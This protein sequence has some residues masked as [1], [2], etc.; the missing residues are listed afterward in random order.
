[1][2]KISTK[3]IQSQLILYF[4]IAILVPVIVISIIASKFIYNEI[5]NRAESKSISD[6]N[7]AGEIYNHR[8][9]QIESITRLTAGRSFIISSLIENKAD[10]LYKE[11]HTILQNEKLDIFTIVDKN[12]KVICRG[13]NSFN[14]GDYITSDKFIKRVLETKSTVSGTD[15]VSP[16]E[17]KK[18][19]FELADRAYMEVKPTLMSRERSEKFEKNGMMMKSASPLF[20]KNK[21]I[22][23]VL[24]S[25][26][27]LNR[28]YDIVDKINNVVHEN[29]VYKGQD[30]G[31]VT[32]FEYDVRI[33]T[34]VKNEDG[35]Y[36]VSTLVSE[37]VYDEVILAGQKWIGDAF[38]VNS[39]YV[40]AYKPIRDINDRVIGILYVGILKQPFNDLLLNTILIFSSIAIVTGIIIFFVA[41]MFA[42]KISAP[43]RKLE[44]WAKQI[45]DGTYKSNIAIKAPREIE[46]LS[47]SLNLMAKQLEQEKF[48][49][50]NW[51]ETLEN[52]VNQRTE[53]LKRINDQLFRSEKL[54]SIGKLAAGVAHEINNP[55]TG[56]LTNSSLMLEDLEE[57]DPR[58]EDL[59][60][61]V[62]ETIRCREI[63]KRLLDF[64]RQTKPQKKMTDLNA[65]IENIILL[66]RNQ[67]A[68]RNII[69]KKVLD[70][71]IPQIM[72][73]A[74][75]IQQVFINFILNAS[76]AMPNGGQLVV[77]T[78]LN[79]ARDY[80]EIKFSD[81]G[82]GISEKD[83]RRI[84]DPFFTTK[85]QGTG[86]G[87]SISHGIIE[88]HGGKI[89]LDS[90][91]GKGTCFT[92][93]MPVNYNSDIDD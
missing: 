14:S 42:K 63:V 80:I 24:M 31:T 73:D 5:T 37:E 32:I 85:Q 29:E 3:S 55:L 16:D 8:I 52:K 34:N 53:E 54:A 15:I 46:S 38:V 22:V 4:T 40:S 90:E 86:L 77:N 93:F 26:V 61:V 33:A 88:R 11:L 13:R 84:F 60:V 48:E 83:K 72:V 49:L 36:A 9:S 41:V 56:V 89:I 51:A 66:V 64:A 10:T 91:L 6:L 76:E 35:S 67:S 44:E 74:D 47:L 59:Q 27:L 57:N 39:W 2:G 82:C 25:G 92:I 68:F 30:I 17:L 1:M 58:R 62:N 45:A 87:L 28:N 23:G 75:Q 78:S 19:A 69:I 7:S 70:T 71:S 79:H 43:L 21:N 50:E 18:E 81:S 65:L 12:G 20:D